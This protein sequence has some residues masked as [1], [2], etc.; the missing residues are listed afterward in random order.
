MGTLC[1]LI[2][3]SNEQGSKFKSKIKHR[4]KICCWIITA[5]TGETCSTFSNSP[6]I[7]PHPPPPPHSTPMVILTESATLEDMVPIDD[8]LCI[9]TEFIRTQCQSWANHPH[10]SQSDRQVLKMYRTGKGWKYTAVRPE[11]YQLCSAEKW[12]LYAGQNRHQSGCSTLVTWEASERQW[13]LVT[14]VTY[15]YD[16][17][18]CYK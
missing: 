17:Q 10:T 18:G 12:V 7:R 16:G 15:Y 13:L 11:I 14:I 8:Y 6:T 5:K 1:K 3:L 4:S 2:L 9:D